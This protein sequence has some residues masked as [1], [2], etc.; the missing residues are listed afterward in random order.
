[1]FQY[2]CSYYQNRVLGENSV[3]LVISKTAVRFSVSLPAPPPPQMFWCHLRNTLRTS[4]Y[5]EG[6]GSKLEGYHLGETC[7]FKAHMLSYH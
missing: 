3:E 6:W 4:S 5:V 7:F 1:M 2:S